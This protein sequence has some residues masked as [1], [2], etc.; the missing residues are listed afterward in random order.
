MNI[1]QQRLINQG[2]QKSSFQNSSD[3]I[4]SLCAVQAQDYYGSLWALGLRIKNSTYVDIENAIEQKQIIRTWP[5]RH[6][7][8]FV[9]P[10]SVRWMLK[11]L[12]PKVISAFTKRR[13]ELEID[14]NILKKSK[15]IFI[16]AL[17]GGKQITRAGMY[18][19]LDSNGIKPD[20]QRGIHVLAQLS[21]EGLLCFGTREQKQFTFTLLD[22]WVPPAPVLPK[23]EALCILAVKYFSSHGPA[24]VQDFAWWTGLSLTESKNAVSSAGDHLTEY[25][26]NGKTYWFNPEA[27]T[28][29]TIRTAV[30]LLPPFDEYLVSYKDK[31]AVIPPGIQNQLTSPYT[32]LSPSVIVEGRVA[33]VWNREAFKDKFKIKIKAFNDFDQ[34]IITS[35]QKRAEEYC[36]F[37]TKG[38]HSVTYV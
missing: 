14:E 34:K 38:L 2:I 26:E 33:G 27:K 3:L 11:W 23:E 18:E 17:E 13:R 16:K 32:L 25:K 15:K 22:E 30:H 9:D 21:M 29:K 28:G 7:L 12:T 8:H 37:F 4:Q 36:S 19:L 1:A 31:S 6:T 24:A 5:M 10:A 35:I 20:G